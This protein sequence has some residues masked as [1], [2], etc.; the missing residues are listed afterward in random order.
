MAG[1]AHLSSAWSLD[2]NTG[3]SRQ[4]GA[5]DHAS[6]TL[7]QTCSLLAHIGLCRRVFIYTF[8]QPDLGK[9][10]NHMIE[11]KLHSVYNNDCLE[12]ILII[13]I[14]HV[15]TAESGMIKEYQ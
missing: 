1:I 14:H 13:R 2:L 4:G 7:H 10:Y 6:V 3:F 15:Y 9:C 8:A 5:F 11:M 12:F